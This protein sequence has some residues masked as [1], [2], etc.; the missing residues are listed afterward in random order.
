M[1]ETAHVF[2]FGFSFL[3]PKCICVTAGEEISGSEGS[4]SEDMDEGGV[5]EEGCRR[6][7]GKTIGEHI[8]LKVQPVSIMFHKCLYL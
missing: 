1:W 2:P 7:R 3:F 8:H 6:R 4:G 5:A